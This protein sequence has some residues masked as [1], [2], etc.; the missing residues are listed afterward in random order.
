MVI[1]IKPEYE[2]EE[3]IMQINTKNFGIIEYNPED[4]IYFEEGIP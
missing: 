4:V 2:S 3:L 1:P